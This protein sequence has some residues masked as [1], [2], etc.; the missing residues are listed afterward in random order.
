MLFFAIFSSLLALMD[1][2]TQSVPRTA[3]AFAFPFFLCLK[4]LPASQFA[5][6]QS[7]SGLFAGLLIFLAVF[8]VSGKKLGLADVWYSAL[9]GFVLGLRYW[10]MAVGAACTAAIIYIIV[11]KKRRI[12]FIPF[13]ALGSISMLIFQSFL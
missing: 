9:A 6:R 4:L 1:I 7:F 3:F 8:F 13:L 2:K 10:Y 12:P 11:F 5:L